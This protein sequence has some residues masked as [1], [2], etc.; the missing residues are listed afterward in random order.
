[1]TY[2]ELMEKATRLREQAEYDV[3]HGNCA[4]CLLQAITEFDNLVQTAHEIGERE[5][6]LRGHG[7]GQTLGRAEA[8]C[9]RQKDEEWEANP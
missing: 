8:N 2:C 3:R 6:F 5:G 4:A 9:H 1:M 7:E